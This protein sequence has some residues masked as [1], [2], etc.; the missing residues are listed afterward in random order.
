MKIYRNQEQIV[1]RGNEVDFA[2]VSDLLGGK[3]F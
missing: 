1:V 2:D 3:P